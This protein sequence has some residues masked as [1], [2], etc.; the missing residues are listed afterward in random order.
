MVRLQLA[1]APW[2][3]VAGG[4]ERRVLALAEWSRKPCLLE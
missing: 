2:W 3:L 4:G 1:E